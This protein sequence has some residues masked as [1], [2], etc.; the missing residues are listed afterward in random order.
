M[1]LAAPELITISLAN[2]TSCANSPDPAQ[3]SQ[4]S[5]KR[6]PGYRSG[7]FTSAS[8]IE[9]FYFDSSAAFSESLLSGPSSASAV[10]SAAVPAATTA[11]VAALFATLLTCVFAF[12][13][14]RTA[15]LARVNFVLAFAAIFFI[16]DLTGARFEDVL[17]LPRLAALFMSSSDYV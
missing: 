17:D 15:D 4:A 6:P 5:S 8:R 14:G 13:E 10:P 1:E 7:L 16:F 11:A 3:D 9:G 12:E 2:P